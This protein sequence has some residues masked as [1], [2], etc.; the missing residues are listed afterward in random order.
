LHAHLTDPIQLVPA[1]IE[2]HDRT[3]RHDLGNHSQ[4][5]LVDLQYRRR[6][7]GS[8]RKRGDKASW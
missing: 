8:R 5:A 4:I 2:Q 7:A 1:Q 3:R 6:A